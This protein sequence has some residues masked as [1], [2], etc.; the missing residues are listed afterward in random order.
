MGLTAG[1]WQRGHTPR[2][3]RDIGYQPATWIIDAV[4]P[5]R[6]T[7]VAL[8]LTRLDTANK[9]RLAYRRFGSLIDR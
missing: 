6:D 9:S 8:V 7:S 4:C 5:E 1:R 2:R 3:R